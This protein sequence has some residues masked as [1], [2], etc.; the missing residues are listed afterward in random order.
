MLIDAGDVAADGRDAARRARSL[1]PP[2]EAFIEAAGIRRELGD[3]PGATSTSRSTATS[4]DPAELDVFMPEPG[5]LDRSPSSSS[6][7]PR[8]RGRSAPGS[9]VSRRRARNEE[10]LTRLR[11]LGLCAR[12]RPVTGWRAAGV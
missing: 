12:R 4:S 1:D 5:G 9:P 10:A 8:F 11:A 3:A 7:S 6:S 2:E